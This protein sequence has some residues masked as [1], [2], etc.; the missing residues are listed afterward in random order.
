MTLLFEK[1]LTLCVTHDL[2]E[3]LR[4]ADICLPVSEI[5]GNGFQEETHA[6]GGQQLSDPAAPDLKEGH[7]ALQDT[8]PAGP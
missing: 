7:A 5:K 6:A 1:A 4:E 8:P 3:V 2:S